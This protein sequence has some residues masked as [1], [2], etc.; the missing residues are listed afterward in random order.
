MIRNVLKIGLSMCFLLIFV[1]QSN[2]GITKIR[3]LEYDHVA[4]QLIVKFK[5]SSNVKALVEK[6]LG[7]IDAVVRKQFRSSKAFSISLAWNG[8]ESSRSAVSTKE[9]GRNTRERQD[10]ISS[11]SGN[12]TIEYIIVSNRSGSNA[13]EKKVCP[14]AQSNKS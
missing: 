11:S 7:S 5:D 9:E 3:N 6:K 12:K 8:R 1:T 13:I 14:I 2:A 10:N 4:D